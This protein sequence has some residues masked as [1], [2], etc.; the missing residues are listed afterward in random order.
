MVI[1]FYLKIKKKETKQKTFPS[2]LFITRL[3]KVCENKS[4]KD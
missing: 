3:Q 1:V 2:Y 4:R